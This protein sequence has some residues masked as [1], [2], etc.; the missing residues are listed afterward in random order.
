MHSDL[1]KRREFMTLLGGAAAVWPCLA[2]AQQAAT[3]VI[4]YFSA[5]SPDAEAPLRTPF[6]K[7][8]EELGFT[9]GQNIA[10]EYCYAEGQD[11]R[12]PMLAAELV[13]RQVAIL[14]ATDRPAA[15]AVKMVTST[16]PIVFASGEDP[17]R[18]GLVASLNNPGGNA[19]GV[20]VFTT[21]LGPSRSVSA[22]RACH[23]SHDRQG[24]RPYHSPEFTRHRG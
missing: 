4:G 23:Q 13:D 14:V 11:G 12:L 15:L 17:V 10:I 8:L 24:A 2:R 1:L 3:P 19:T 21:E 5:R 7:A 22:V 18:L 6:L 20:N 16:T 9:A